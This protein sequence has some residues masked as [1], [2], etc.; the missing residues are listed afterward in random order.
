MKINQLK[1]NLYLKVDIVKDKMGELLVGQYIFG[2][3][4]AKPMMM[5]LLKYINI[6]KKALEQVLMVEN[7]EKVK[8]SVEVF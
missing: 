1:V 4:E 5:N 6:D 3:L 7:F 2:S 8:R